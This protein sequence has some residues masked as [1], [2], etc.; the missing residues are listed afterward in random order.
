VHWSIAYLALKD[1]GVDCFSALCQGGNQP[2]DE[3]LDP[4]HPSMKFWTAMANI[5][6]Y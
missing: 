6:G 3:F 2:L 4:L 5:Q 1:L